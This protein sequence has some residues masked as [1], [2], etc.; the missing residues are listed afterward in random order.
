MLKSRHLMFGWIG[1]SMR[2]RNVFLTIVESSGKKKVE[3]SREIGRND[4]FVKNRTNSPTTP[5]TETFALIA[6][7]CG[8]DL[9]VRN[10][11]DGSEIIIDPP[12]A[13]DDKE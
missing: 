1:V 2:A 5:A 3:I 11:S 9:L 7:A 8:Y 10:R 13:D 12:K 6:D 4:G